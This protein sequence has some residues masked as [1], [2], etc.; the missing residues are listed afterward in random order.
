MILYYLVHVCSLQ[1]SFDTIFSKRLNKKKVKLDNLK[2]KN[3]FC[4]VDNFIGTS[5]QFVAYFLTGC[6]VG[7]EVFYSRNSISKF[8]LNIL[9][10]LFML[11]GFLIIDENISDI[12]VEKS[13]AI[14]CSPGFNLLPV[15]AS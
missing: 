7:R 1:I 15:P 12:N 14:S 5:F 6:L 10:K 4:L 9:L 3:K 2:I 8:S 11:L 13:V